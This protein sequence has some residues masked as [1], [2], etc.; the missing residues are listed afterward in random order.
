MLAVDIGA[1]KAWDASP[2]IADAVL[3]RTRLDDLPADVGIF[4]SL[5]ASYA[6]C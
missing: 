4:V 2:E 1:G 6:L 5:R 3:E